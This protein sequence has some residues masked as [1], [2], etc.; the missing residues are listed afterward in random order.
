M[1]DIGIDIGTSYSSVAVLEGGKA[2][3]IKPGKETVYSIPSAVYTEGTALL[4]GRLAEV[5][6]RKDPSCYKANFKKDF[7]T[8]APIY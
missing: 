5:N 6:R 2:V 1:M 8:E 3:P 7:G 4:I